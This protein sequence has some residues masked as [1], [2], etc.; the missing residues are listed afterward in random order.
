MGLFRKVCALSLS[1]FMLACGGGAAFASG[2]DYSSWDST[3]RY[4]SDVINTKYFSAVK[5]LM[6][7]NA[8]TGD[9][10][11]LFHPEKPISRAEFATVVARA[12][13]QQNLD[14]SSIYFTDLAG[15][16][17]ALPYINRCQEQNWIKGVGG[18]MFAPGR[19]VTYAEVI[20]ILIRVQRGGQVDE[21]V[22]QWPD[23]YIQYADMYNLTGNIDILNWN[24]A[25]TKGD[26]A[27][28]TNRMIPQKPAVSYNRTAVFENVSIAGTVGDPI[29]PTLVTIQ[30]FNDT[31]LLILSETDVSS[32]FPGLSANGLRAVL[33]QRVDAGISGV[34]I[35]ISGTPSYATDDYLEA[36]IPASAL[37]SGGSL[38]VDGSTGA[39]YSIVRN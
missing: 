3:G 35:E 33:R 8:I 36:V 23:S 28:L 13:H 16:A 32:W 14:A 20:T 27:M 4:P 5:A 37:K 18:G 31:F 34:T 10:D 29:V 25:A 19:Q 6:D 38:T 26:V 1:A 11:G 2:I 7:A 22:G 17:W 9:T 24:A 21:L 39:Y 30:V 12:T 15:Y